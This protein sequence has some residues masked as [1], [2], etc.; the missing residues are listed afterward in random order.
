MTERPR[1]AVSRTTN[2]FD[3][4][5]SQLSWDGQSLTIRL[6]EI[7]VPIPRRLRGTVRVFPRFVTEQVF[8]L[9][10]SGNHRWWPVAPHARVE[11]ALDEPHLRWHG[12]GYFDMNQGDAPLESGFSDWQWS[13]GATRDGAVI[14]YEAMRRDGSRVDLA[15]TFDRQG[16]MQSFEPPPLRKL[17]PTGWRVGRDVRSEEAARISQTLEDAPFYA[18][19]VVSARL[20]GE[21]VT[22]M[23]ESLSLDRFRM[24][25]V[26]AMLPFRMPRTRR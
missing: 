4:G 1:D 24:P 7:T 15:M 3:V 26:Q 25:I 17:K 10:D 8:A 16:R 9:N 6:D 20:R 13:R 21:P 18:R 5:P 11:V 23:H 22:L 19:S 14:L 12:D 2:S